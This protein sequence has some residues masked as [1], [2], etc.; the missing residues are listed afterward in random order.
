MLQLLF[1]RFVRVVV[2][3]FFDRQFDFVAHAFGAAVGN[4]R[5]HETG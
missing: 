4:R 1:Q 3:R 2:L 5:E